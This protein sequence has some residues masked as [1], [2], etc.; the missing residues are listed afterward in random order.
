M[1]LRWEE[2]VLALQ[3]RI[4]AAGHSCV[5][6]GGAVRDVLR[7]AAPTDYDLAADADADTLLA[8]LPGS[9]V[10]GGEYGTVTVP[11]RTAGGTQYYEIT[12]YR[13]EAGYSD[14][15]HPDAVRFG[16]TLEQDLARRDLT[17]NAM[18]WDGEKIID[19]FNGRADL[20]G[21]LIRTVG[22][23][24]LRFE[25]D[26][27]RILR[28]LR[29][30]SVLDFRLEETTAA[31]AVGCRAGVAALPLPRVRTELAAAVLGRAPQVLQPFIAAGGLACIGI[32]A[33]RPD[34][35]L[36]PLAAVPCRMLTRWW[37][38]LTLTGTDKKAFCAR[39]GF[40]GDFYRELV[41]LDSWYTAP[42]DRVTLKRRAAKPLSAELTEVLAAFAA[43]DARFAENC[44]MWAEVLAANEP[45]TLDALAVNGR[46]LL[47]AG[48]RGEAIGKRLTLLLEA[49]LAEP[50]LNNTATLLAMSAALDTIKK[51]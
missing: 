49:V 29:F 37:A 15:R 10:T 51:N 20:A 14:S 44:S 5:L 24:Q 6:V 47:A 43:L 22:D 28:A 3:R 16:V 1:E 25:E 41:L 38:F 13:A 23:A 35:S 4:Q 27:L 34:F 42:A 32:S 21:R 40:S 26:A 8:L 19:P 39:M 9:E 2:N 46:H 33:Q 30:A 45:C 48:L 36:A 18:A 50:A 7:G 12:P 31:A 11:V 17:V